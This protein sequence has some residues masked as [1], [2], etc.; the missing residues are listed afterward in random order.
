MKRQVIYAKCPY[1]KKEFGWINGFL[2]E[3][4]SEK[5]IE[6]CSNCG[7]SSVITATETLRFLAKKVK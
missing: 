1:C 3:Y 2:G 5:S 4:P 6:K 7:N